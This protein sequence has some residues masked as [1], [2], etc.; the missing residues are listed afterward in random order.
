M[1][2]EK[3]IGTIDTNKEVSDPTFISQGIDKE[4]IKVPSKIDL[5]SEDLDQD[6]NHPV[7]KNALIMIHHHKGLQPDKIL[8]HK[9]HQTTKCKY[10]LQLLQLKNW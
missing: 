9:I 7:S 5:P 3:E 2:L 6:Q 8:H 4:I 1:T 10:Q